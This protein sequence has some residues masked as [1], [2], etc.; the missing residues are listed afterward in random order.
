MDIKI[1]QLPY[2]LNALEPH[3]SAETMSFHYDR[4]HR[5][6]VRKLNKLIEGTPYESLDLE[7]II[8]RSRMAAD[9]DVLN[10]AA[11]AWNHA[12]LWESMSPNGGGRPNGRVSDLIDESFGDFNAFRDE[13]AACAAQLFGSGWVWLV[14]D[15]G[16]LRIISTTNA[17]TPVGTTA[18]PL[19]VLDVWE[20]AYYVDYRNDRKQYVENFLDH[21]INWKFAAANLVEKDDRGRSAA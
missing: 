7:M 9:I 2:E 3:I 19:L 11:Q 20:H 18:V 5:G 13:F 1:P 21:L 14:E 12:F 17:D 10:N 16:E 4:H 15:S 8:M 6:Y